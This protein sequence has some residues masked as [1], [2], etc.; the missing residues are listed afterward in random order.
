VNDSEL[1]RNFLRLECDAAACRLRVKR[2]SWADPAT[3]LE[4]WDTVAV[5]Q[6]D[7]PPSAVRT[8]EQQALADPRFF[9]VCAECGERQPTGYVTSDEICQL[10]AAR[11]HGVVF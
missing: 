7:A 9:A 3:P 4:T 10:C 1:M 11:N 6:P 8:A 5:L 2:I